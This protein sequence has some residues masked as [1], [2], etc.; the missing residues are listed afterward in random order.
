MSAFRLSDVDRRI[1][2][3]LMEDGRMSFNELATRAS[4]SRATAYSRVAK[5]REEGVITGFGAR[6]DPAALGLGVVALVLCNV[7]QHQWES[8][9]DQM[10]ELPGLDYL[11]FTSGGFDIAMLVRVSDVQAL[12]DVILHRIHS[13][14]GVR[15]T[16]TVFVLDEQRIAHWSP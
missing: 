7:E 2:E 8:L 4:V 6:V 15:S 9:R 16:Q 14:E 12:R 10:R 13:M 5:L 3:L 1:V 11:A